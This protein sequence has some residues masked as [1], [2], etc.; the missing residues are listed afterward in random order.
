MNKI[1]N[2][3]SFIEFG[4]LL[5]CADAFWSQIGYYG[6]GINDHT[7]Q[8]IG[9]PVD[10]LGWFC[11]IILFIAVALLCG[12]RITITQKHIRVQYCFGLLSHT[13]QWHEFRY[14]GVWYSNKNGQSDNGNGMIYLSRHVMPK[15]W[16]AVLFRT[17]WFPYSPSLW[18]AVK[19]LELASTQKTSATITENDKDV[20]LYVD[21]KST[22]YQKIERIRFSIAVLF[23][24]YAICLML[25]ENLY[26]LLPLGIMTACAIVYDVLILRNKEKDEREKCC[27]EFLKNLM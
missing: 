3:F 16:W 19:Q 15:N 17:I 7:N 26:V 18:S 12:R 10:L 13:Y 4:A 24:A 8:D 9:N 5:L 22:A 23:F 25:T 6:T 1:T 27:Q 11:F 2:S 14:S 21:E 20:C